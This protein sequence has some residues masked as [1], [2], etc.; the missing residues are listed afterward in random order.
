[1]GDNIHDQMGKNG[2]VWFHGIVEDVHDP[3]KMGRVRVRCFEYHNFDKQLLPTENLPWATLLQPINS[4][5]SHGK[6]ISPT[7]LLTGSWVI[8]FFRDGVN[9]QDP[10]I[11]GSFAGIPEDTKEPDVNRLARNQSIEKTIVQSKKKERLKGVQTALHPGIVWDEKETAYAAQY[12]KNHVLETESGHIIELDDTPSAER[13]GIYHKAGTWIEIHPDGSRVQKTK[14]DDFEIS[15]SDK[16]LFV[17]GNCFMNMEGA[18]TTLKAGKDFYI[19]VGGDVRMLARGNVVMET[20]KNFE[21]RVHGTYTVASDGNMAFVA[22]RIDF[23]PQGVAVAQASTPDLSSGKNPA[24]LLGKAGIATGSP[25]NQEI[26]KG[27]VVSTDYMKGLCPDTGGLQAGAFASAVSS[28]LST[29]PKWQELQKVAVETGV[30]TALV[31][32]GLPSGAADL[33]SV[34]AANLLPIEE[35]QSNVGASIAQ[36]LKEMSDLET[37]T[38]VDTATLNV[39]NTAQTNL[40][41]NLNQIVSPGAVKGTNEGFPVLGQEVGGFETNVRSEAS[42]IA[43]SL[44]IPSGSVG[45][46]PTGLSLETISSVGSGALLSGALG[47][48]GTVVGGAFAGVLAFVNP[49]AAL[50]SVQQGANVGILTVP[51]PSSYASGTPQSTTNLSAT[52]LPPVAAGIAGQSIEDTNLISIGA[53]AIPTESLYAVPGGKATVINGYP[54]RSDTASAT[55]GI[56]AIPIIAF[57]TEFPS[58]KPDAVTEVDGG[59]F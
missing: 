40:N 38:N 34:D 47:A 45:P 26:I 56:P 10:V 6:G 33:V 11:M 41:S 24:P 31:S 15:L 44:N 51:S 58:M 9:C 39:A 46:V 53:P 12:P 23:N 29:P 55:K 4:A 54:G 5:A 20:G 57:E 50:Q 18:I 27:K 32:A 36:Q 30:S 21:H 7:G 25:I 3:L 49:A 22:P 59:V 2:F 17:K 35:I 1:M 43:N 28:A 48:V 42:G 14:G 19:E 52:P 8:G 16:K 37:A 13:I